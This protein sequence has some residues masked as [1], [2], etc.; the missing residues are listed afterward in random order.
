MSRGIIISKERKSINDGIEDQY[1]NTKTPLLKLFKS[2]SD[3]R[4]YVSFSGFDDFTIEHNLGYQPMFFLFADRSNQ[5][6]R[7]QVTN[8]DGEFLGIEAY[9]TAWVDDKN[10]NVT[11]HC[12]VSTTGTFG[13][14]YFIYHDRIG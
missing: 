7:K 11:V 6:N 10:I 4:S 2:G 14:N 12:G 13:Y 8:W 1:M 3:V 5:N 9:W